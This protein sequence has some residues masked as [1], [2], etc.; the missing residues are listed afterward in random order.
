MKWI[1]VNDKL[2]K[3]HKDVLV[4]KSDGSMD[5]SSCY[6]ILCGEFDWMT[7]GTVTH[8]RK[9]PYKPSKDK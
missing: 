4:L 8:W 7:Y 2:P 3:E 1:N 9:L 5:V 6:E